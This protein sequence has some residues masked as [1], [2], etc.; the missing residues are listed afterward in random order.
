MQRYKREKKDSVKMYKKSL[1]LA[2]ELDVTRHTNAE[3]QFS[4]CQAL[5]IA[6]ST[7]Q[8]TVKNYDKIKEC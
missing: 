5:D 4:V 8:S 3:Y 7:V 1:P 2:V 6:S